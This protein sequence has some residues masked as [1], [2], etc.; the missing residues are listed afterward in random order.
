[1][2]SRSIAMV[3]ASWSRWAW[4]ADARPARISKSGFAANMAAIPPPSRSATA[5]DWITS[6]AR[7][8]ACRSRGWQRRR[9]RLAKPSPLRPDLGLFFIIFVD[10]I[11]TRLVR[12]PVYQLF[13][14]GQ[15]EAAYYLPVAGVQRQL[16]PSQPKFDIT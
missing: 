8:T 6:H 13:R 10:R 7:R 15:T 9:R 12:A 4:C 16:T 1:R 5:S 2:L 3:W 11:F 14:C